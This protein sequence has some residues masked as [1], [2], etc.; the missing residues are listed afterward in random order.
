[1][2]KIMILLFA[3]I[4]F[5][6]T[7]CLEVTTV[8]NINPDGTGTIDETILMGKEVVAMI[9]EF[10]NS[11][12]GDTSGSAEKFSIFNE[13]EVKDKAYQYGEGVQY[14]SGKE[15]SINGKEGY[16]VTY[17][18]KDINKLTIDQNPES[19]ISFSPTGDTV[20]A[21]KES[22]TFN[23]VKGSPAELTIHLPEQ[24][25]DEDKNQD[26]PDSE[27]DTAFAASDSVDSTASE[28]VLKM[29]EGLKISV[30]LHLNGSVVESNAT[31]ADG[32]TITLMNFNLADILKDKEKLNE[33][34][35]YSSANIEQLQ[36][37]LKTIPGIQVE[38]KNPV[39]V[40][41]Q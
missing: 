2:K 36:E 33:L 21:E 17:S 13:A 38:L 16:M 41:F 34:K 11:F 14:M 28:Q 35:T 8:V 23:M 40:K 25:P 19:K 1:M 9:S 10:T 6:L 4:F 12:A 24:K 32:S 31:Y 27:A 5:P 18:F 26:Q 7:G 3:A 29:M 39:V 22:I 15:L 20:Q 30:L 37:I